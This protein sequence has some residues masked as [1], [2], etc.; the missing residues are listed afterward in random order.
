MDIGAQP[1]VI[2]QVPTGVV[3]IVVKDDLVAVPDPVI[4][5][6]IVERGDL[7]GEAAEP[8]TL[9]V[10]SGDPEDMAGAETAREASVFPGVIEVIVLI[11]AAGIVSD[12]AVAVRVDVWSVRVPGLVAKISGRAVAGSATGATSRSRGR[13]ARGNMPA[14]DAT[15]ARLLASLSQRR[16]GPDQHDYEKSGEPFHLSLRL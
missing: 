4:A 11:A 2:G 15:L 3:G 9:P 13:A 12:P 14:A 7:E 1:D 6:G 16:D 10:S 5:E 8:E